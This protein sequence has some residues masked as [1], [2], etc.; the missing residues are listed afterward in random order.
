MLADDSLDISSGQLTSGIELNS[1]ITSVIEFIEIYFAQFKEI[2]MGE[3]ST[4]EKSLT[5]K[6][7]KY[8]NRKAGHLPYYFHHENVENPLSGQSPQIDIGTVSRNE[9]LRV[10][11][12]SY[13]WDESFFSLEAKRLPIPGTIREKEYVTGIGGTISGGIQR[14]K[15][16]KHGERLKYAAIIGYIQQNDARHWFL[17]INEWV[18][19]LIASNPNFWDERDKLIRSNIQPIDIDKYESKHVRLKSD[20]SVDEIELFH[21]W[22]S[23]TE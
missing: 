5:D 6:L 7:C 17:R 23:L 11:D 3:V 15:H 2:A 13:S 12:R 16:G 8:F 9:M 1:S 10:G 4:S 14:F 19:E 20:G 18:D 21:F 22:I